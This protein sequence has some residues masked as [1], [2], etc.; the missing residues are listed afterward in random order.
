M[1]RMLL[2]HILLSTSSNRGYDTEYSI[3]KFAAR[4]EF[5]GVSGMT[6]MKTLVWRELEKLED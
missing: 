5:W 3:S 2:G 1:S 4:I 6:K